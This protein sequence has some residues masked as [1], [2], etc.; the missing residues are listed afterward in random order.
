M[1][2]KLNK[3]PKLSTSN[4]FQNKVMNLGFL[5]LIF[6]LKFLGKR[7]QEYSICQETISWS[8]NAASL[9]PIL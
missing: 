6:A 5:A 1:H 4:L 2:S 7:F 8:T 3:Y 9:T